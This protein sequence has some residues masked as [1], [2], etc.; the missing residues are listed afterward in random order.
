MTQGSSSR[1]SIAGPSGIMDDA[2]VLAEAHARQFVQRL[3]LGV[4]GDLVIELAAHHEIDR[5]GSRSSVFSGSTVTG[6]PTNATF[7]FGFES[8]I[9][10]AIFTS[11]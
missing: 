5:L 9:I 7:S 10:S 6:G 2:A 8:F 3:A 1:F 11:T 4:V